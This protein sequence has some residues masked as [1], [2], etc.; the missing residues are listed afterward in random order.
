[1][2]S[3]PVRLGAPGAGPAW[4]GGRGRGGWGATT[5]PASSARARAGATS[6]KPGR[7][8]RRP[9]VIPVS[10]VTKGGSAV[11][12]ST[13]ACQA[14]WIVPPSRTATASSTMRPPR[15]NRT[16]LVSTSTT[17]KRH[18]S[19]GSGG[20]AGTEESGSAPAAPGA[21]G[22]PLQ[23]I[24][25]QRQRHAARATAAPDQLAPLHRNHRPLSVG[26]R[27]LT[28]QERGGGYRLEPGMRELPER[29]LVARVREGH[30]RAHGHEVAG[31]GPLLALLD[32]A[33]GAAAEHRLE[34]MIDGL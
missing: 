24:P 21:S 28:R 9:S 26:G 18:R 20:S 19:S 17:A 16:P 23:V 8:A 27:F 6:A 32:R 11:P 29:R 1:M 14:R 3:G 10:R 4:G 7:P 30:A 15:S 25:A 33:V 34:P 31:R 5:P 22:T 13:S 2:S 12:G